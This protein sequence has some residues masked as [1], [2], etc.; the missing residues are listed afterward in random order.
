MSGTEEFE[1]DEI[2]LFDLL[3][4]LRA[5]WRWVLGGVLLGVLGS[6]ALLVLTPPKYEA[7]AL[8]QTGK[9]AGVVIEDSSTVVERLKA[10]A[11]QLEVARDVGDEQWVGQIEAGRGS[12]VLSA[13]VPKTS[14]SMVEVK[15]RAGSPGEAKKIAAESTAKLIKRQ[16]ELSSQ[17]LKKTR[18]DLAVVNEKLVKAEND[19]SMLSKTLNGAGVKD[20]RFSQLTLL[21]SIKL[22]KESDVFSLRQSVFALEA[23][24][25]PPATQSARML[26]DIFASSVR[27]SPKKGLLLALGLVGG[28]LAGVISVFVSNAWRQA[29]ERRL[30]A[31]S[32][33]A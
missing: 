7:T 31:L 21:T 9:V 11:F 19:L 16:D 22:Q 10:P 13:Q 24:L 14:P 32:D 2:S 33:K 29:R 27:V 26:E 8:L 30:S 6:T 23:S 4:K 5:G 20:E 17:V 3:E 15:V 25:L 28:L 18:F 12:S 1:D